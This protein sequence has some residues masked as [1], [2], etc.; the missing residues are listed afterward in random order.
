MQSNSSDK[1]L[2]HYNIEILNLFDSELQLI[3][4]TCMIKHKLKELLSEL[5]KLKVQTILVLEYQ[6]KNNCKIVHMNNK[7][8]S[9]IDEAFISMHQSIVTKL[10]NYA[11]EDWTV[12]DVITKTSIKISECASKN[13]DNK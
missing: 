5:I 6:K 12:L 10:R 9:D 11:S 8:F 1:Y 13:E 7:L 3:N 2:H 4:T